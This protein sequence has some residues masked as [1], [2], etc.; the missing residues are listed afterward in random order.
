MKRV[1]GPTSVIESSAQTVSTS[2]DLNLNA[3]GADHLAIQAIYTDATPSAKTFDTGVAEVT[4]ITCAADTGVYEVQTLTFDT[5]ANTTHQDLI[6]VED[7]AAV[8]YAI[9]LTKP[10]AAVSTLTFPTVAGSTGGDYIVI[11]DTNGDTWAAALNKSGS[12]PVPSGAIYT[13]IPA[14]RKVNVNISGGTDEASVA[15]LVET[16]LNALTGFTALIT[17]D[18]TA[19]DG[20]MTLTHVAKAPVTVPVPHNEND[21][22]AGSISAASTTTGVASVAPSGALWTAVGASRRGLADISGDTSA[23]DVAARAETAL[24]A[25]TGFTAAITTDDTAANGTM[26]L[27]QTRLGPVTNPVP[28]N[29]DESGAGSIAGVQTTGGVASIYNG[30]YFTINSAAD[31]TAYYV[32]FDVD[33]TGTDPA[34]AS[35]TAVEVN[36]TAAAGANTVADA[37]AA[38]LDALPAFVAPNPAAAIVSCTNAAVGTATDA[39]NVDVG[40]GFSIAISTQGVNEEVAT[41]TEIL[42]IPSHGFTTGLKGQ[43]TTTGTLPA[44]LS[45]ATD[46]FVI[47]VTS[48]TIKFATSL[49]LAN[50]GTAVD[51]TDTGTGVHTFT[52][53]TLSSATLKLQGSNDGTNYDDLASQSVT[54]SAAGNELFH[55][56]NPA[57]EYLRI[58]F[59]PSAGAVGLTVKVVGKRIGFSA[60]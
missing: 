48:G 9:A 52:P 35:K 23:A 60:E 37:V 22:G 34:P 55:V 24:N 38:A 29:A 50:A 51:I 27:T 7:A 3:I 53:T 8:K 21:A 6:I 2:H 54:I 44:G 36:I 14:G 47:V 45:L 19:A 20:T 58:L 42:S 57:Y 26:T 11:T 13:A 28:K 33:N 30:K 18:D 12:D 31:A 4:A 15:A 43:L 40:A 16:A 10:V 39:A 25:L 5:K 59:T 41:G 49:A 1:F 17:T 46:Y 32:W 56:S